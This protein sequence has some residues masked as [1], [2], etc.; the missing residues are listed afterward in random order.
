M[1]KENILYTNKEILFSF[2]KGIVP[3]AT[4]WMDLENIVLSVISQSQK[5]KYDMISLM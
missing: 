3:Y 1:N 5:D 4:I 2:K